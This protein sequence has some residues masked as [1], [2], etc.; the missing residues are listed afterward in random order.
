MLADVRHA[1]FVALA[2]A[3]AAA[4][5]D[6]NREPL[7]PSLSGS[8][9]AQ[10]G[11]S[12]RLWAYASDPDLDSVS[13]LFDW[14]DGTDTQWTEPVASGLECGRAH[15][16]ADTGVYCARVKARDAGFE[17]AWSDSWTVNVGEYGPFVPHRPA[18]PDTVQVG[19]SVTYVTAAGH[20]LQ[21]RVAFQFD[22]GDTLGDWSGF[23]DAGEFFSVR[24]AFTRAGLAL[25]RARAHDTLD[26]Q[27]GWSRPESVVVFQRLR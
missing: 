9:M 20:P 7:T 8:S 24:H 3:L 27:T 12:A 16:Y 25:V 10:R 1:L 19:D 5:C 18:G 23:V 2:M 13:Y 26:H 11:D 22:W 15:I 14:R 17:T 4:G 6:R 21:E